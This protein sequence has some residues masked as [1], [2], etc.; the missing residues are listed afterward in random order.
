MPGQEPGLN[1]TVNDLINTR[2]LTL[3]GLTVIT[4]D[5]LLTLSN[6]VCFVWAEPSRKTNATTRAAF[7][8]NRYGTLAM[9]VM[10]P[11]VLFANKAFETTEIQAY[12]PLLFLQCMGLLTTVVALYTITCTCGNGLILRSL[13]RIW[14]CSGRVAWMLAIGFILAHTVV[15][16]FAGLAIKQARDNLIFVDET[17]LV[18]C[19]LEKTPFS[20]IGAFVPAAVLD[21]YAFALLLLNALSRPR[22]S[23][24]RLLD[25]LLK[26]GLIYFMICACTKFLSAIV[27]SA[28]PTALIFLTVAFGFNLNAVATARLFLRICENDYYYLPELGRSLNDGSSSFIESISGTSELSSSKDYFH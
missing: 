21:V 14:E 5:T 19:A 26:D 16:G 11:A 3:V 4:Y 18:V 8:I 10:F 13:V 20:F 12:L 2:Y 15:L 7:A 28:A 25:I 1:G 24:Q 27:I 6:E 23:T 17:G 9:A 22:S